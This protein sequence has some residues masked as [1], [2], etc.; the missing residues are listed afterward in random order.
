[1][2]T[3]PRPSD[4][5]N[6]PRPDVPKAA[7]AA[8][9]AAFLAL[10]AF[11]WL[12]PLGKGPALDVIPAN[13]PAFA[14]TGTVRSVRTEMA[15]DGTAC[16]ACHD[17]STAVEGNPKDKGNVHDKVVLHHGRNRYCFNCHLRT[18]PRDFVDYDG[19]AIKLANV[20]LLCAKCH[21]TNY[22]DWLYGAHGRRT[23]HWEAS[24][25]KPQYTVCVACHD[26]HWPAFKPIK[27]AAPP[28][29]NPRTRKAAGPASAHEP[30][31]GGRE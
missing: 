24:K 26:P 9:V 14:S 15:Y 28:H 31:E 7:A 23:G 8:M 25:G 2:S 6:P 17:G 3:T 4:P 18:Q 30:A 27:A 1:M 11:F 22:R 29:V 10:V 20:Q 16:T 5:N 21:G 13:D 19:S 12:D